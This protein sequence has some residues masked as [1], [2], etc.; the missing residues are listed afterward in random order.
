MNTPDFMGLNQF[1]WW[2]GVVENRA[3]PLNLGRCQVR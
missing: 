3:D 2:F 1:V